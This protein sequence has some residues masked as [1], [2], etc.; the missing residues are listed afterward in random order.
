ML[1]T[2]LGLQ[3]SRT[4]QPAYWLEPNHALPFSNK[5]EK[6]WIA[7][8]DYEI[9]QHRSIVVSN[10]PTRGASEVGKAWSFTAGS[11]QWIDLGPLFSANS[12]V[13]FGALAKANSINNFALSTRTSS[14]STGIDLLIGAGSV[15]GANT[16]RVNNATAPDPTP[17]SGHNDG[18]FH[19]YS[20]IARDDS[21]GS[22]HSLQFVNDGRDFGTSIVGTLQSQDAQNLY[23]G[24]RGATYYTGEVA[25]VWVVS[26]WMPLAMVQWIHRNPWILFRKVARG[27][28]FPA[29]SGQT[30]SVGQALET[31]TAQ[32]IARL[33]AKTLG[34][35]TETDTA[36]A[37]TRRKTLGIGQAVETDLAQAVTHAKTKLLGQATETDIAQAIAHAKTKALAQ[38]T[39]TD[40]AQ[41]ITVSGNKIIAVGQ[42]TETDT[43]QAL[44]A[45]KAKQVGQTTETDAAQAVAHAKTKALGQAI[46]TDLAQGITP[47]IPNQVG[48]VLETDLAQPLGVHKAKALGQVA[49]SDVAQAVTHAKTKGLGLALEIDLGQPIALAPQRRLVAQVLETD[50][51]QTITPALSSTQLPKGKLYTVGPR[52]GYRVGARNNFRVDQ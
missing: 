44:T 16:C 39:E 7:G 31:D 42:V 19:H 33:K 45:R 37:I 12:S 17:T 32:A 35:A 26:A 23:V 38:A 24:R 51:A 8:L 28:Y 4:R 30:I 15:A 34:Q 21:P 46:E 50:L 49:E 20:A 29:S 48:A 2:L 11:T 27:V 40:L 36:Q 52:V 41:T 6:L 13:T 9:V 10:A 1:G 25:L 22:N 43:A 47:E 14:S 3:E 18:R 5:F